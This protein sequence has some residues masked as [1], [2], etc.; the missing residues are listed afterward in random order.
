ML[1]IDAK[2][3]HYSRMESSR[4]SPELTKSDPAM[5]QLAVSTLKQIL[6]SFGDGDNCFDQ[7]DRFTSLIAKLQQDPTANLSLPERS[8]LAAYRLIATNEVTTTTSCLDQYYERTVGHTPDRLGHHSIDLTQQSPY[9]LTPIGK[10]LLSIVTIND[11]GDF[12]IRVDG[13]DDCSAS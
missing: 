11:Y 7:Q 4:P 2:L 3:C 1:V 6:D 8:L 5:I 10:A 12:A 13:L 9:T